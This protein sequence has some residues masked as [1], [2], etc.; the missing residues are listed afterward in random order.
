MKFCYEVEDINGNYDSFDYSVSMQEF[1]L[2]LKEILNVKELADYCEQ[3]G[4]ED[5]FELADYYHDD[6]KQYFEA[7]AIEW[8]RENK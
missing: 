2:A 3:E 4:F 1:C 7:E 8:Y 6:L 5:E